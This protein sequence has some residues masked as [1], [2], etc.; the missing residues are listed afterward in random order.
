LVDSALANGFFEDYVK[1]VAEETAKRKA[2]RCR[3][4]PD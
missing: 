1:K 3:L 4:T 2:W